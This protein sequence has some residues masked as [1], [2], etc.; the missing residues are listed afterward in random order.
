MPEVLQELDK[1][2]LVEVR[3][4]CIRGATLW[5]N[6]MQAADGGHVRQCRELWKNIRDVS[7]EVSDILKAIGAE[8]ER[9]DAANAAEPSSGSGAGPEAS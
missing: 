2:R 5:L 9:L 4:R 7:I 8:K 1:N 3:R 6:L